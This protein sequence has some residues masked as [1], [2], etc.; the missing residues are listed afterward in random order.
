MYIYNVY[1][2]IYIY[3]YL[4]SIIHLF[5]IYIYYPFLSNFIVFIAVFYLLLACSNLTQ[6][7][8][9]SALLSV[10]LKILC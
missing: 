9:G 2:Y 6:Q 10:A 8:Q 3:I 7:D 1:I 4:C 5:T